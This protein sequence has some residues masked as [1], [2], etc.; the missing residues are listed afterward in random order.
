MSNAIYIAVDKDSDLITKAISNYYSNYE[1][2]LIEKN[3]LPDALNKEFHLLIVSS[4]FIDFNMLP[5]LKPTGKLTIIGKVPTN[6][7]IS[8]EKIQC[9]NDVDGWIRFETFT[10]KNNTDTNASQ[11]TKQ[12]KEEKNELLNKGEHSIQQIPTS[13]IES[14]KD[15]KTETDYTFFEPNRKPA[16]NMNNYPTHMMDDKKARENLV[17]TLINSYYNFGKVDGHKTIGIWSPRTSNIVIHFAM[18]YAVHLAKKHLNVAVLENLSRKRRLE[19]KLTQYRSK[20]ENWTSIM[21]PYFVDKTDKDTFEKLQFRWKWRNVDWLPLSEAITTNKVIWNP[22]HIATYLTTIKKADVGFVLLDDGPLQ[23]ESLCAINHI[24]ELWIM[25]DYH[26]I[27]EIVSLKEKLLE[28]SEE[29]AFRLQKVNF[30]VIFANCYNIQLANKTVEFL[31]FP[32]L[33]TLPLLENEAQANY[34]ENS[35]L[36]LDHSHLKFKLQ[37]SFRRVD[38]YLNESGI[39]RK[40]NLFQN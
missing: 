36:F 31:G 22:D 37:K 5:S 38:R 32:L 11:K 19:Y 35:K 26:I 24:D 12:A 9:F 3:E 17:K 34:E 14:D 16:I 18:N 21:T 40:K 1:Y 15:S 23:E 29:Y 25:I 39:N 27:P 20:P 8:D 4:L 28:L 6:I 7:T 13:F 10:R 2:H 33:T 30:K